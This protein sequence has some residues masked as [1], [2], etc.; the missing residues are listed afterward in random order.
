MMSL[1]LAPRVGRVYEDLD[2]IVHV[3]T[4]LDNNVQCLC[5]TEVVFTQRIKLQSRHMANYPLATAPSPAMHA[6]FSRRRKHWQRA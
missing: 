5:M 2:L 1:A 3:M 6:A 4:P